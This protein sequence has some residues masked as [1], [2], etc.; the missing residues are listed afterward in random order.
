MSL[1]RACRICGIEELRQAVDRRP[2]GSTLLLDRKW[3]GEEALEIDETG[4][5][6]P[7]LGTR[8][9]REEPDS[10]GARV[11]TGT[12]AIGSSPATPWQSMINSP[13]GERL[14]RRRLERSS[15]FRWWYRGR[16]RAP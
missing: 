12:K 10:S 8:P 6:E 16:G 13:P 14:S 7:M 1:D 11:A 2:L 15:G 3:L 4:A 5:P 9:R